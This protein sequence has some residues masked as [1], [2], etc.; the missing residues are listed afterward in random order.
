MSQILKDAKDVA[1][2]LNG[3]LESIK[4]KPEC[5]TIEILALRTMARAKYST[6]NVGHYGLG[7]DYYTHF[8]SPIRRYP[9]MMVHRLLAH[10][11]DKGKNENK[12]K[13][14]ELCKHSSA[15]EQLASEAERS[16]IKYKLTEFMENKVGQEFEG[17]ISGV[18]EW[19]LYVEIEPTKVEGMVPL[20]DI[21]EDYFIFDEKNYCVIG[22]S[23]RKKFTLGDKVKIKVSRTNLEQKLIDYSLIW[24]PEWN[25][26]KRGGKATRKKR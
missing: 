12:L 22:K 11:L 4:G 15:R 8:T 16:S 5:N 18:T 2:A 7:F 19:G 10:Y 23:T 26:Q 14:E 20:K 13:F 25:K 24:D 9:D 17:S 21:K 1:F 6:D 3:L